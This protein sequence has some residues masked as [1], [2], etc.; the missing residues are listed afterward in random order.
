M[1]KTIVISASLFS[2]G[3][4]SNINL[5]REQDKYK[6]VTIIKNTDN[7]EE[8]YPITLTSEDENGNVV[9]KEIM[10][11]VSSPNA[12]INTENNEGIVANDFKTTI[13]KTLEMSKEELIK[14]SNAYAWDIKTKE[15]ITITDFKVIQKSEYDYEVCFATKKGTS[16]CVNAVELTEELLPSDLLTIKT[17]PNINDQYVFRTRIISFVLL[18]VSIIPL[19]F[20]TIVIRIL[21]KRLDETY[22]YIYKEK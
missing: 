13:G 9:E 1:I 4:G 19:V 15:A 8:S 11:T 12:I 17:H 3:F 2:L 21:K 16:T 6:G 5:N 14:H 20:G 10:V 7:R 18:L 22:Y